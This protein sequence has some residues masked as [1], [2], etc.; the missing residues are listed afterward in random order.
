MQPLR[1]DWEYRYLGAPYAMPGDSLVTGIDCWELYRL[2]QREDFGKLIDDFGE[3]YHGENPKARARAAIAGHLPGW[4]EVP[5]E[6][7][8]G[9]LFQFNGIPA[10]IGIATSQP[11]LVLH[12]HH[13]IGVTLLD[14]EQSPP[15]KARFVGCFVPAERRLT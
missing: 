3:L 2:V 15:W 11:G 9:V 10:H 4:R 1:P 12:S 5:W 7:G 14:L 13:A 6:E 8:A